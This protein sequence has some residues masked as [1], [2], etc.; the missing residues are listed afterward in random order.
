MPK[1]KTS[2]KTY[3]IANPKAL[4]PILFVVVFGL[5]GLYKL[6]SSGATAANISVHYYDY[7]RVSQTQSTGVT[8]VNDANAAFPFTQ[9]TQLSSGGKIVY[10]PP[11]PTFPV[12][13]KI[14]YTMRS[15]LGSEGKTAKVEI[16][17]PVSSRVV[18]LSAVNYYREYCIGS[19]TLGQGGYEKIKHISGAP[20]NILLVTQYIDQEALAQY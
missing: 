1:Q 9:V 13:K 16:S 20:V 14:C 15:A 7:T 12:V 18:L 5:F 19:S 10:D 11:A 2:P 17:G 8:T 4:L 3:N 6:L